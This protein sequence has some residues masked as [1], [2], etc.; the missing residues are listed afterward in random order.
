MATK[1][2][3]T[4]FPN[5]T[6]TELIK[7]V[8]QIPYYLSLKQSFSGNLVAQNIIIDEKIFHQIEGLNIIH[9][10]KLINWKIAG[11]IY[12]LFNAK[13]IDW[14]NLYHID[15]KTYYWSWIYKSINPEGK[16]YLK[17]DIDY[18]TCDMFDEKEKRRIVLNKCLKF[19][20]IFSVESHSIKRRL[21]KHTKR[22]IL[23]VPNGSSLIQSDMDIEKV[24][25]NKQNIF[26]TVG[27][28]GTKQKAT[29]LLMEA[30]AL[31]ADDCDWN[32]RLVG[33]ITKEFDHYIKD[34]FSVHPKL[35]DRIYVVGEINDREVLKKEYERARVFVLPSRWES[36]G[37]SLV[38]AITFGCRIIG[39]NVIPPIQEITNN[40]RYGQIVIPDCISD[41]KNAMI[42]EFKHEYSITET[43]SIMEYAK[44]NYS[45]NAICDQLQL[46][47][48]ANG[49]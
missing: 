40:E 24:I 38:E 26:L 18:R 29:E 5:A 35:R 47:M 27:R 15:K 19:S 14:L 46:Y 31:I 11:F 49:E 30:F 20:S 4:L 34:F 17:G 12:I 8:G 42:K 1:T 37:I 3:T 39:T 7:D 2:F 33:S 41:L 25:T 16:I 23:V 21:E 48:E 10:S 36:F 43:Q 45:W 44:K 28:L 32:L 9:L 22:K 6:N 13:K